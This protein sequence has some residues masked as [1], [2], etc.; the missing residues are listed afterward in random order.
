MSLIQYEGFDDDLVFDRW[1]SNASLSFIESNSKNRFGEVWRGQ[2]YYYLHRSLTT[3]EEDDVIAI[4]FWRYGAQQNETGSEA[5]AFI[6]FSSD[7]GTTHHLNFRR[8]IAGHIQVY[9]GNTLLGTSD[10]IWRSNQDAHFVEI[11]AK[12]HDSTG[13]VDIHKDGVS[14]LS[15]TGQDTKN[16]GT[17]TVF[18]FVRIYNSITNSYWDDIYIINEQ[19]S[20][21]FNDML[22][23]GVVETLFPNGN[24]NYSDWTGSDADSTDNYLHV[25][26]APTHDG[27]TS[28]VETSTATDRESYD[29]D[30]L[31][32]ASGTVLGVISTLVARTDGGAENIQFSTRPTSTD[33][34]SADV[35][36]PVSSYGEIS[37]IWEQNPQTAAAWTISTLDAAEFGFEAT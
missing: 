12:L 25:D 14:V 36:V 11:K 33:Y 37:H 34:D 35:A 3:A 28:Y 16:G 27:D 19:G 4:G 15:L 10:V 6:R 30:D 24:G 2:L 5:N 20:A 23:P 17:K 21:P 22:G 18:D 13:T 9:R 31:T 26:E 29:F 1:T 7:G 8:T 32:M